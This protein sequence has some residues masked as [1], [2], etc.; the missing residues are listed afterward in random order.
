[1]DKVAVPLGKLQ[2][3]NLNDVRSVG[4]SALV[5][6]PGSKGRTSNSKGDAKT[7]S[8]DYVNTRR[9]FGFRLLKAEA[10]PRGRSNVDHSN[11]P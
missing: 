10:N 3:V 6:K 2:N 4:F 9:L 5:R 7:A 1:M 11:T 8:H